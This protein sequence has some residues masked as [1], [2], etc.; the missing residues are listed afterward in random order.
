M[1]NFPIYISVPLHELDPVCILILGHSYV[2]RLMNAQLEWMTHT[3]ETL[4]ESL[5]LE[6]SAI[7]IQFSG[8]PGL[9]IPDL[10]DRTFNHMSNLPSIVVLE[11]GQNDL[12]WR[13][14]TPEKMIHALYE[15]IEAMFHVFEY[16]ET[17]TVCQA[18]QKHSMKKG[19]KKLEIVNDHIEAFNYQFLLLTR[20]DTRI[21]RW[22]HKGL[23]I[24]TEET[25][26][27]GTHPDT[28][29][30]YLQYLRSITACCKYSK[31]EMFLRRGKSHRAIEK[32]HVAMKKQRT[33][34][35]L[36]RQSIDTTDSDEAEAE[37]D[38]EAH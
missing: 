37:A 7:D 21:I 35:R 24:L 34:R 25:T 9:M 20:K 32:R 38:D 10:F 13:R 14:N 12:C 15:Q 23:R 18:L 31:R 28:V 22:P 17:V 5:K 30:G 36:A 16:L 11:I 3:G 33:R 19:D 27:D 29:G 2:T 26:T 8:R 1:L 6:D 4:L